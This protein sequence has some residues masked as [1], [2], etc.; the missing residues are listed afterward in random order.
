LSNLEDY[1]PN[2]IF[3]ADETGIFFNIFPSKTFAIRGDHAMEGR[4]AKKELLL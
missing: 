3:N 1:K 2:D 4:K